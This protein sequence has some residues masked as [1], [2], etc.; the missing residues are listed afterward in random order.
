MRAAL[1][2]SLGIAVRISSITANKWKITLAA[3]L[4]LVPVCANAEI[5]VSRYAVRLDGLRIGDATLHTDF[6]AKRYKVQVSASVGVLL[7]STQIQ[8]HASGARSGA[9]LTP[10]H[11]QMVTSGSDKDAMEV[12]FANMAEASADGAKSLR[13]VFDPLSALLAA[14][15]KPQSRTGH[16]C[17]SVLPIFTGRDSFV[18][19]LQPAPAGSEQTEPA[20]QLCQ[21]TL[22]Q[23]LAGGTRLRQFK[24]KIAFTQSPKPNFWLVERLSLPTQNGVLTIDRT[25][26]SMSGR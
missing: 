5:L 12:D 9:K 11:F 24:W 17:N 18:L 6:A 14:S 22:S 20:L 25:E 3:L 4:A 15:Y 13:G 10:E 23:P 26:T 7:I 8:G 2:R 1:K 19:E 21:I 16:P